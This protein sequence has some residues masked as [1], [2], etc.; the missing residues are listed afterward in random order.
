MTEQTCKNIAIKAIEEL[1]G[2]GY[3][4]RDEKTLDIGWA[5]IFF[6]DSKEFIE[7]GDPKH[8]SY[9]NVPILVDKND[10]TTAFVNHIDASD[11]SFLTRVKEMSHQKNHTLTDEIEKILNEM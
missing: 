5:Y 2:E 3:G 11:F 7:T 1:I 4:V 9:G 8:A 6:W 10:T